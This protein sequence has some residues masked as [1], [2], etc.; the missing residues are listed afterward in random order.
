V[1]LWCIEEG[2]VIGEG[3]CERGREMGGGREEKLVFCIEI[4]DK[5]T[6]ISMV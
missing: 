4:V 1:K 2:R 5:I 3:V 6:T